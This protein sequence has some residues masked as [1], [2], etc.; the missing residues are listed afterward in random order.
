MASFFIPFLSVKGD[1][2]LIPMNDDAPRIWERIGQLDAKSI[3]AHSRLDNQ[4]NK[5]DD[6]SAWMNRMKGSLATW[7]CIGG[8]FG[9]VVGALIQKFI[10]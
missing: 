2:I 9:S 10:K 3:A 6:I 7:A 1:A 5:I 4:E 8:I